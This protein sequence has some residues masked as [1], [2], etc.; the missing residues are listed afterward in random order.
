MGRSVARALDQHEGNSGD[1]PLIGATPPSQ[2]PVNDVDDPWF[3]RLIGEVAQRHLSHK[4]ICFAFG[5]LDK[6]QVT[7]QLQGD[8]HLSAKRAGNL[9]AAVWLEIADGIKA[10]FGA[11]DPKVERRQAAE[12]A[13]RA[14]GRLVMVA[15]GE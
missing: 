8:G 14:I 9:P 13:M 15:V 12:D 1:L 2:R 11:G 6:G 10:H 4:E 3:P 5:G 7:R